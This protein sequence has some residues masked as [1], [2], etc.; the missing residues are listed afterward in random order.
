[1]NE[2][3][4][5]GGQAG[6]RWYEGGQ[7][8]RPLLDGRVSHGAMVHCRGQLGDYCLNRFAPGHSGRASGA[9]AI[10]GRRDWPGLTG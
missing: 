5:R 10:S 7:G 2:R 3:R 8:E 6:G 4:I 9:Q 1:M